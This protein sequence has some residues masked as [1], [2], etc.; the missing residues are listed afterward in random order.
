MGGLRLGGS[1]WGFSSGEDP[2]LWIAQ[3]EAARRIVRSGL[4]VE[5]WPTRGLND[6]PPS[7]DEVLRLTAV[8]RQAPFASVHMRGLYWHWNPATLRKEID[9]TSDLGAQTLV[10][11]PA[12]LGLAT[13]DD[14]LDVPRIRG[15]A[16]YAARRG[17]RLAL[18][19]MRNGA[20]ALDRVLAEIGTDLAATN[21]GICVDVGHA[22]LST[23]LGPEPIGAYLERYREQVIHLHLHDNE[24][25]ADDHL[26]VGDGRI[27]WPSLM[28]T[29]DDVE[30]SGTCVFEVRPT[31]ET[32][33]L[34]AIFRSVERIRDATE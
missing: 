10:I 9:L 26:V 8:C 24:G 15:A 29:L 22:F 6:P 1:T 30:F 25:T 19:N 4:G 18:E 11:H 3:S 7:R 17:V 28:R 21:L 32:D 27:D 14:R 5:V 12:C 20:W 33:C 31:G 34:D 13:P 16:D 23:D 2:A